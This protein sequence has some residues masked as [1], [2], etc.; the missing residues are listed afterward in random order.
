MVGKMVRNGI[1]R[2][3][4]LTHGD[5]EPQ[6]VLIGRF[7]ISGKNFNVLEDHDGLLSES[8]PEGQ[9]G[10]VHQKFF[11]SMDHNPYYKLVNEN[12]IS[13]GSHDDLMEEIDW[14][15]SN[16]EARYML[17]APNE[18]PRRVEMYGENMV[19]DGER[20]PDDKVDELVAA[21]RDGKY[22]L[23]PV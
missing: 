19:L 11:S 6:D 2:V 7:M 22:K 13:Q 16:P 1:Y 4:S 3:Y 5:G 17:L 14:G 20:V 9:I 18:E 10:P 8:L 23:L 12:H 21:I 15:D